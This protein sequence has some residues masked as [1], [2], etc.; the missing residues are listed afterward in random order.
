MFLRLELV[1]DPDVGKRDVACRAGVLKEAASNRSRQIYIDSRVQ[2]ERSQEFKVR[3]IAYVPGV[4]SITR[5][6]QTARLT[7]SDNVDAL[8]QAFAART[9]PS[10]KQS[11][12]FAGA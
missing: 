7:T 11:R 9:M 8:I 12:H 1:V 3:L 4:T 5:S 10:R 2:I 6:R